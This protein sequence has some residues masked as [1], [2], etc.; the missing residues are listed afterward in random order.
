MLTVDYLIMRLQA[1][2]NTEKHEI[3]LR[4]EG[5]RVFARVDSRE[6]EL[7]VSQ[8][9]PNVYLLKNEGKIHQV[10]VSPRKNS[11]E[12]FAVNVGNHQL[13]ISVFD[14]KKLRGTGSSDKNADGIV[15]IKTAMPGKLV[16]I[17]AEQGA[18]IAAGEGV[19]VVEAVNAGDILAIIE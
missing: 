1:E 8:P 12:P 11:A 4:N 18:E 14:P 5:E 3:E 15:E 2:L 6:Y 19:L 7:E 16:R 17:L 9:E 13:E 10:F